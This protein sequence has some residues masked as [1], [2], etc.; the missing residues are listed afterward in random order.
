MP[1]E[2]NMMVKN[3][4]SDIGFNIISNSDQEDIYSLDVISSINTKH[5]IEIVEN[6][7]ET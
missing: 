7:T 2:K 3:L 6:F 4:Y 1:T 5:F